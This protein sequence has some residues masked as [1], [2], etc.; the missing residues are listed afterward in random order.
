MFLP[1]K[2]ITHVPSRTEV[3]HL[4]PQLPWSCCDLLW[5]LVVQ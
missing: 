2:E 4:R 1:M 5:C 3:Q